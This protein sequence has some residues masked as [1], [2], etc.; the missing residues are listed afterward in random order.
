MKFAALVAALGCSG[1]L[2]AS[3]PEVTNVTMT[4]DQGRLVTIT[5]ALS[6]P[7]VVTFD[8]QTNNV[9]KGVWESIG[10]ERLVHVTGAV[11][12][13]VKAD[14]E[15]VI[16]WQPRWDWPGQKITGGNVKCEVKAWPTNA[17]PPFMSVDLCVAKDVRYYADKASVFGG[18]TNDMYK[19]THLLLRKLPAANATFR[20]GAAGYEYGTVSLYNT[21]YKYERSH[22]VTFTEDFYIGVYPVTQKQYVFFNGGV[23]PSNYQDKKKYPEADMHPVEKVKW[24]DVRGASV[25][26]PAD[27]HTVAD[28]SYLKRLRDHAG[29]DFDLPTDAQWEFACRA[30]T[31]SAL[32]NGDLTE[33]NLDKIGWY[34]G[35]SVSDV[36]SATCTWPVGRK[37]ANAWGLYDMIGNVY[38]WCLDWFDEKST[39]AVTDPT[40]A[41]SGL[42]GKKVLRGGSH[43]VSAGTDYLYRFRSAFRYNYNA[44]DTCSQQT[45]FRLFAPAEAK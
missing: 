27:L 24:T 39:D 3:F 30:G 21:N 45:G 28:D 25:D 38:E 43:L 20:M 13:F 4:Q 35:N 22:L 31:T 33:T 32:Y 11:N 10:G 5:Y 14:D 2:W 36:T 6:E 40:G 16:R 9:E 8:I 26:W 18:V 1:A 44:P 41:A 37:D 15:K 29:L 34:A 19:T 7:A 12:R 17:P 23:N 42:D